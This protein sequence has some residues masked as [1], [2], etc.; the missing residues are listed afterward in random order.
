MLRFMMVRKE[1]LLSG[2]EREVYYT[3]DGDINGLEQ[4]L[5]SGGSSE[6]QYETHQL[7]GVEVIK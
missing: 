1:K 6:D 4:A 3:I 5:T 2:C 7:L